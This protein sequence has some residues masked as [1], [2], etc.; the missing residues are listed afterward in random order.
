MDDEIE[1]LIDGCRK[2]D[3]IEVEKLSDLANDM[4]QLQERLARIHDRGAR[5]VDQEGRRSDKPEA[6][7]MIFEASAELK[8]G[9]PASVARENGMKSDGR[10]RK[11]RETPD[12]VAER[13]WFDSRFET[14]QD[15]VD[16]SPGWNKSVMIY[17]FGK[18]GR[19]R[20]GDRRPKSK[21]K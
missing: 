10:P 17:R 1:S 15:A 13:N 12:D 6:V 20:G 11:K 2:G 21:R 7:D 9:P 16:A 14:D 19:R 5:V 18:S 8:K 3:E 4:R